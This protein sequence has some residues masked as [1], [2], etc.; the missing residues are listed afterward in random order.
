MTIRPSNRPDPIAAR[1]ASK[2]GGSDER[3]VSVTP[4]RGATSSSFS[5]PGVSFASPSTA[6]ER[7]FGADGLQDFEP[8]RSDFD[9]LNLDASHVASRVGEAF[10]EADADEVVADGDDGDRRG[11]LMGHERRRI[12]LGQDDVGPGI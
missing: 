12:A 4:K 6:T 10:G 1:L 8:F 5:T 9:G 11:H 3:K 7:T 2:S